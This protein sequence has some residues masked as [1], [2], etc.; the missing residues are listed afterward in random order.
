M[1]SGGAHRITI[2]P[3]AVTMRATLMKNISRPRSLKPC[4]DVLA[5][6]PSPLHRRR[7]ARNSGQCHSDSC[8][9]CSQ[10]SSDRDRGSTGGG[11]Q[12]DRIRHYPSSDHARQ[13]RSDVG[14]ELVRVL[15]QE[16]FRIFS[17]ERAREFR[18]F[19]VCQASRPAK[20]W[21]RRFVKPRGWL[22]VY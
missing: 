8:A 6:R 2:S 1:R 7:S 5:G 16:G 12:H 22:P 18:I 20:R 14:I 17:M 15:S 13:K 11:D 4:E 9:T 3:A 19:P 10:P 21:R